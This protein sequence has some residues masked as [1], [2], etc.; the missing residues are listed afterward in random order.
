MTDH[1]KK[2]LKEFAAYIGEEAEKKL[3]FWMR[4]RELSMQSDAKWITK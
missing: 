1:E 4:Q 2:L 3:K